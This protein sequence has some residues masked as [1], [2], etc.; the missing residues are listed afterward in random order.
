MTL[1]LDLKNFTVKHLHKGKFIVEQY[2]SEVEL[3]ASLLSVNFGDHKK[4]RELETEYLNQNLKGNDMLPL[5]VYCK[6][7]KI[8]R[9]A[10]YWREAKKQIEI[11]K[12]KGKGA[13][14]KT[15]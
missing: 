4:F 5:G 3:I 11:V 9:T 12:I 8:T 2:N 10:V 6:R 7:E 14:V 13:F 15:L 1:E